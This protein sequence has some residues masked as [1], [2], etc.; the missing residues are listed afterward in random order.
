[1]QTSNQ[2][3][4]KVLIY[5]GPSL[6]S[7]SILEV[8]PDAII[9]PPAKQG[10]I[11]SD[12]MH[13]EP[14]HVLLIE[15]VFHQN[16][17][18]WHKELVWAMQIPGVR[19]VYGA[20]S[21]GALRA[22]DMSDFGMI[23]C[24][25]IFA[26][27]NEGVITGEEEVAASY[28][29]RDSHLIAATIPLVDVRGALLKGLED[30]L[31]EDQEVEDLLAR[32]GAIHWTERTLRAIWELS[33]ALENLVRTHSQK[34]IDALQLIHTFR[35]L[36][37]EEHAVRP[38]EESLSI[39]F[40]A[41]FDRDRSVIVGDQAIRLQ[42]LEAYITLHDQDY[43]QHT[44]DADHRTLSLF[45]ADIYRINCT[46]EEIDGEWRRFSVRMGLRS[47]GDHEKWLKDN[48][49]NGRE[50]LRLMIENCRLRKLRR[51]LMTRSGP[52]R[53]TQRLLDHLKLSRQY[54]YWAMGAAHHEKAIAQAGAEET[55]YFGGRADVSQMLNSHMK[56]H[57]LTLTMSLEDYCQEMGFSSVRELMCALARDRLGD[58][59][60]T[61]ESNAELR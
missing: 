39:L 25:K 48:H 52:R 59:S 9:K 29:A 10:D 56:R 61:T 8:I 46:K 35:D 50:L 44:E 3:A 45:L 32:A 18:V 16:L 58:G 37:P 21:M 60:P 30:E 42:D 13:Y 26:W 38:T 47:L 1:M 20:A 31:F 43:E 4:E 19:A 54:E 12:V 27:Y 2:P 17:S 33:P 24:G 6:D 23:G 14:T 41:G 28:V 36:L 22:A 34:A 51:A 15:G 49:C 11:I 55:L 7:E 40:N 5:A 57:G 53:R